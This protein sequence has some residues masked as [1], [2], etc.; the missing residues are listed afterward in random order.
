MSENISYASVK[1]INQVA[2]KVFRVYLA[3]ETASKPHIAGQYLLLKILDDWSAFSIANAPLEGES[4]IEL[5]V[6][7]KEATDED[8]LYRL[9]TGESSVIQI[10]YPLGACCYQGANDL[11]LVAGGTGFSQIKAILEARYAGASSEDKNTVLVWLGKTASD[12]YLSDW[13][14]SFAKR[15]AALRYCPLI[16]DHEQLSPADFKQ[17]FLSVAQSNN[18]QI[19]TAL[20][21]L[22]GSPPMVKLLA[23]HLASIGYL[24][25][26]LK[27]DVF[28]LNL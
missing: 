18:F 7:V 10:K 27:S 2:D 17:K 22:A 23:E 14:E 28:D 19:E 4:M 9:L 11:L 16:I 20:A 24:R 3:L 1:G 6:R 12:L 26:Q 15:H 8:P 5:H 13:A 21:Y 25:S